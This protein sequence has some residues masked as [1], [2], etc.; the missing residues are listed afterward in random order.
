MPFKEDLYTINITS[1]ERVNMR[2]LYLYDTQ[3]GSLYDIQDDAT[4]PISVQAGNDN[5]F[6]IVNADFEPKHEI[7]V[8]VINKR[9]IISNPVNGKDQWAYLYSLTG[10]IMVKEFLK[11]GATITIGQHIEL[12]AGA[13]ILTCRDDENQSASRK[14]MLR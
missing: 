12:P 9:I 2:N 6:M 3:T 5:R 14:V 10:E 1:N 11:A 8:R 7:D 13:Y 4:Y